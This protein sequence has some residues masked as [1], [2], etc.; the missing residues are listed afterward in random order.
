MKKKVQIYLDRKSNM[1]LEIKS[2]FKF[3]DIIDENGSNEDISKTVKISE[4]VTDGE[5]IP[6]AMRALADKVERSF[7]NVKKV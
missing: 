6:R 5:D 1:V 7:K 2:V 4:K 3:P